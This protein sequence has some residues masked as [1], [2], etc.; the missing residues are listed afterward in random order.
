MGILSASTGGAQG[1][2]DM[3]GNNELTPLPPCLQLAS[4]PNCCCPIFTSRNRAGEGGIISASVDK[5]HGPVSRLESEETA[6]LHTHND[7]R[8][9][10]F[11]LV[12]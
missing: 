9:G 5:D 7:T 6:L 2:L 10:Y 4:C 8:S 3:G 1:L 11:S 12:T